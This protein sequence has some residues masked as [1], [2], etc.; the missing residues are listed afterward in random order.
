MNTSQ[1]QHDEWFETQCAL[2]KIAFHTYATVSELDQIASLH[3]S[4]RR[5]QPTLA[6]LLLFYAR[7]T[8]K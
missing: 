6:E 4:E 7:I 3:L 1:D 5:D 8:T 2:D